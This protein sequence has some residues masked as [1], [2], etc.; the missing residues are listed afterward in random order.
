[1]HIVALLTLV[2]RNESLITCREGVEDILIYIIKILSPFQICV[3]SLIPTIGLQK[4][5]HTPSKSFIFHYPSLLSVPN[6]VP[7][8]R[9][10]DRSLIFFVVALTSVSHYMQKITLQIK[11]KLR[12]AGH[13]IS[14][15][16]RTPN[17]RK[18]MYFYKKKCTLQHVLQYYLMNMMLLSNSIALFCYHFS[19]QSKRSLVSFFT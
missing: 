10:N 13:K 15:E 5:L 8:P 6:C 16:L 4:K 17:L 19:V 9:V 2:L 7:H 1:M 14:K 18:N 3:K 11:T 12:I